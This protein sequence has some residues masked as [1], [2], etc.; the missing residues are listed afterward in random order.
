MAAIH[1]LSEAV[2]NRIAA[3]EVL[4]RPAGAVK[5]LVENAI[6]AGAGRIA[7]DLEEGGRALLRVADDGC[8]MAP[9]ELEVAI[10]HHATSKIRDVEDIYGITSLGFRGEAL[11]SIAAVSRTEIA[12]RTAEAEAGQA[13]QVEA[14]TVRKRAPSGGAP[15]TVVAVRDLF[16]NTP[17][18][19]RF[20][21]SP[22]AEVA[23]AHE[24]VTRLALAHPEIGFRLTTDGK[25]LL[26][27]PAHED[28]TRRIAALFGA[29]LAEAL[30]PL[31][32]SPD[33]TV[34]VR[35]F[36]ARPPES[37]SNS[38]LIY[39][40]LNRRP[41]H[42][43]ALVS[44]VRRACEGVLAPRRF[45]VAFLYLAVD[46]E[47]VDVNVH[48]TKREVRFAEERRVTGLVHR[49][50][51]AALH[52][53][54]AHAGDRAERDRA[55]EGHGQY[56]IS[57]A[58]PGSQTPAPTAEAEE[59]TSAEGSVQAQ[60]HPASPRAGR[61][62]A[63]SS[64]A[65][66]S[67]PGPR[68]RPATP[69]RGARGRAG[70]QSHF[71]E[72]APAVRHYRLIG[73]SHDAYLLVEGP[74]EILVIDQHAMHERLIYEALRRECADGAV[75]TL[76]VPAVLEL[77]L[78]ERAILETVAEDLT[79]MGF[80]VEPFGDR[81]VSVQAVPAAVPAGAGG[82]VL[83]TVL[84]DLAELGQGVDLREP[85]L[86]RL[87]CRAA[88]KAGERMPEEAILALLESFYES[89]AALTCPHGRPFAHRIPTAD[90]Q[91]RFER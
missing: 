28:V 29:D 54:G 45:P 77:T 51:S 19:R 13:L 57:A 25:P 6:D 38:K 35:G 84:E 61:S 79:S 53:P 81:T 5:E 18:R 39:T 73:Q 70:E 26:D 88:V 14:G 11:P 49:A 64:P 85:L 91:R 55:A 83:R 59:R 76:L 87:A 72:L 63:P 32:A 56:T 8:G 65:P 16:F 24:V 41:I 58:A 22:R 46:P 80:Q 36:L 40:F 4:E 67:Q 2:R 43:P 30:M 60:T 31:A 10:L 68:P 3:G 34:A 9:D 17:A 12:S 71:A 66:P 89:G 62:R 15:G 48:P 44:V 23:A 1:V 52:G 78:E 75:Q 74:G 90:L 20:L 21:K 69:E 42:S 86:K 7:V 27:V 50:L 37:R 82:R 33:E 47:A